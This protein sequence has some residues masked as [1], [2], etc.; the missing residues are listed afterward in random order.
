MISIAQA[1]AQEQQQLYRQQGMQEGWQ[2]GVQ[3]VAKNMLCDGA[4]V[5]QVS[6]WTGLS[7]ES[8][9]KLS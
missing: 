1:Y 5:D 2:E 3:T 7:S 4:P 8:L 6:K 9:R